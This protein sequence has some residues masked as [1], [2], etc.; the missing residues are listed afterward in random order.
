MM[1]IKDTLPLEDF[2]S[3]EYIPENTLFFDIETTGLS[4]HT[5]HLTVIGCAYRQGDMVEFCQYFA[6]R[7]DCE[8]ELLKDFSVLAAHFD[9]V[10]HFNGATFD[11]AYVA[12]KC[13]FYNL[14]DP[15]T[16]KES[17]DLYRYCR[18]CKALFGLDNLK[19]KS[20]ER[21]FSFKRRDRISGGEC[22][23]CYRDYLSYGD[24]DARDAILLHNRE[25]VLGLA[26]LSGLSAFD[27]LKAGA[28]EVVNADMASGSL[29]LTLAPEQPLPFTIN[30]SRGP[31]TLFASGREAVITAAGVSAS[32]N[33]YFKDYKDYFYIPDEDRAVHKSVGIYYDKDARVK[34]T[35][36]TAYEKISGF[37]IYQP[38]AIIEPAFKPDRTSKLTLFLADKAADMTHDVWKR[39]A[40]E[41]FKEFMKKEP[42]GRR[43]V[44]SADC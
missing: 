4:W 9:A 12:G 20:L 28:F 16:G 44:R 39:Y 33:Y 3:R 25:D 30:S 40:D 34:A 22:I 24:T 43:N 31:Y 13:G 6:E 23:T 37:F 5:S 21:L 26:E 1:L 27:S 8:E 36:D 19:Q 32:L 41:I 18:G 29:T 35:K 17:R 42:G 7:P 14:P 10:A 38:C 2:K 11:I 15:F